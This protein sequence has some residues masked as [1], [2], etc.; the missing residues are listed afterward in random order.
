MK[1]VLSL[2][3]TIILV[4]KFQPW[5]SDHIESEFVNNFGCQDLYI[6]R[7]REIELQKAKKIEKKKPDKE[8]IEEEENSVF[9]KLKPKVETISKVKNVDVDVAI[10]GNK[11]KYMDK[12]KN[13]SFIPNRKNEPKIKKMSFGDWKA[14]SSWF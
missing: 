5:V 3:I 10:R 9:A 1:W 11:Y 14:Q 2:I 7:K 4:P 13:F 12:I 8:E 6:D